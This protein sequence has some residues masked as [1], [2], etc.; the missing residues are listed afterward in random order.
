MQVS[1]F[2]KR[3]FDILLFFIQI[4]IYGETIKNKYLVFTSTKQNTNILLFE[5]SYQGIYFVI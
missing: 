2:L 1:T 4:Q 5:S 3:G